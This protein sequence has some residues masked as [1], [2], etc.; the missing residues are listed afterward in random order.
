[1]NLTK[2]KQL[3]SKETYTHQQIL[4]ILHHLRIIYSRDLKTLSRHYE[5]DF[6]KKIQTV[7]NGP[8]VYLLVITNPITEQVVLYVGKTKGTSETSGLRFRLKDHFRLLGKTPLTIFFPNWWIKRIYWIS[9]TNNLNE[10]E[11]KTWRLIKELHKQNVVINR[12]QDLEGK[13]RAEIGDYNT[14]EHQSPP[15]KPFTIDLPPAGTPRTR[16]FIE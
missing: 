4:D 9:N 13:I 6:K 16:E 3:L 12:I 7:P 8:G 15:K 10:L 14:L 2:L 5:N 11:K 1:M